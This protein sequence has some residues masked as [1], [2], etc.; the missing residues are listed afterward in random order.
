FEGAWRSR[1][2]YADIHGIARPANVVPESVAPGELGAL[3]GK[4]VAVIGVP[5]VGDYDAASTA[6]AL[7]ELHSVE[8]FAENISIPDLPPR[9]LRPEPFAPTPSCS[10]LDVTS[11]AGSARRASRRSR[12]WDWASSRTDFP[13]RA[14]AR[15]CITSNTSIRPRRC[16]SA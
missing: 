13:R 3:S 8:A 6:Q 14:P 16:D 15:A 12:C 5:E 2:L 4:R 1:G 10:R 7:K 9:A 11:A